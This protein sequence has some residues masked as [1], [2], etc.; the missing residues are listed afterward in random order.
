MRPELPLTILD[1][2]TLWYIVIVMVSRNQ[3]ARVGGCVIV[4]GLAKACLGCREEYL[5][6]IPEGGPRPC[7]LLMAVRGRRCSIRPAPHALAPRH[8]LGC[9]LSGYPLDCHTP[10]M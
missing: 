8:Q 4:A 5:H 7:P 10:K 9:D 2:E 1:V 3:A 6:P